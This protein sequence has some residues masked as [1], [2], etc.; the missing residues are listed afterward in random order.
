[1]QISCAFPPGATAVEDARLAE[2][3]GY[4]RCWFYDSP[5]LY[6]DV[7]V[8]LAQV[9]AGTERIGLGPAVLVPDQRHV[10]AQAAA[11]ATLEELA[12]G[13]LAVAIGT[14]FTGRM[15]MGHKAMSWASAGAYVRALRGLLRGETVEVDGRMLRMLHTPGHAPPRPITTPILLGASGPK[16][17]AVARE[18]ADGVICVG[19]PQPG[20]DRSGLL[21]FGTVH[22][23]GDELGSPRVLAAAGPSFSVMYHA[24][25]EQDPAAVDNL[26]GG[27]EWRAAVEAYPESERHLVV[28]EGHLVAPNERDRLVLEHAP[29]MLSHIGWTADAATLRDRLKA[30]EA[31]GATEILYAPKGP[32]VPRELRAFA[33]VAGL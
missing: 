5:A 8:T 32:D 15:A 29:T 30:T 11:I 4:T 10:M 14:G 9:A 28:H 13:R 6:R 26:P 22:D 27:A 24:V 3:L 18:L 25:W 7:W 17:Q 31:A 12:P 21:A 20:W 33:A 1:V 19:T 2:D 16:G 23:E